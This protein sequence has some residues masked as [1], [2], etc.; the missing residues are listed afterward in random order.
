MILVS[1]LAGCVELDG[2]VFGGVHCSTVGPET[3]DVE[4][5]GDPWD[6]L[7]KTC[8]E[9]YEWDLA[10]PW[11]DSML[12]G[13][14]TVRPIDASTVQGFTL[15]SADGLAELDAYFIPSHGEDPDLA[16]IT[17]FY[18]HGN[19]AGIEHYLPRL[20][21]LHELGYNVFVWDYRGYGKTMP[22]THPT[23][24]QFLDDALVARVQAGAS[25]PD[26]DR[27]VIYG[28][29][30]GAIPAVEA[31]VQQPGCALVLE[32]PFTSMN[33][34]AR[35]GGTAAL[36]ESYLSAGLFDTQNKVRGYE[37]PLLAMV[38]S[39]DGRFIPEEVATI[40]DNAPGPSELWVLEG[41][42]HGI[43]NGGVV[44]AGMRAYGDRMRRF[45]DD[46][47]PRCVRP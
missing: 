26:P 7:C 15:P 30:L 35:A 4:A 37:G 22:A 38:G 33:A 21:V 3:C 41:V 16:R 32:A 14:E 40:V 1:L 12:V 25:A 39:E 8:D 27:V 24:R 20:R 9:P 42:E 18:N 17:V 13:D 44:E 2:F 19:Y 28:Y 43:S 31:S 29:S 5:G 23:P 10:Y 45:Y 46:R 11:F 36:P 34:I 47:A 6:V